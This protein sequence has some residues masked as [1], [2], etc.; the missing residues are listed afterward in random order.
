MKFLE[1]KGSEFEKVNHFYISSESDVFI[2]TISGLFYANVASKRIDSSKTRSKS[3]SIFVRFCSRVP[4]PLCVQ[5]RPLCLFILLLVCYEETSS[6]CND[7]F[8][9]DPC[10]I[11]H[12]HFLEL[13][14]TKEKEKG[15][16]F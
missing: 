16:L 4:L 12:F 8:K 6:R 11:V 1:S 7:A 5:E 15:M 14:S 9:E 10:P 3:H 13:L 2:P